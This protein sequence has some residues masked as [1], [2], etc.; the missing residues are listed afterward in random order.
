MANRHRVALITKWQIDP[1]GTQHPAGI[2]ALSAGESWSDIT[3]QQAD[4]NGNVVTVPNMYIIEAEIGDASLALLQASPNHYLL[5]RETW[6]DSDPT[7]ITFTNFTNNVTLAQATTFKG[8]ILTRFP[9]AQLSDLQD[10][11]VD[12]IRS[13]V[14]RQEVIALLVAHWKKF[15]K[16][17]QG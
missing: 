16:A 12:L 13:G 10:N 1:D 2:G 6:D 8:D 5:A 4:A 9:D 15:I 11:A 17:V 14:T 3:A 7:T